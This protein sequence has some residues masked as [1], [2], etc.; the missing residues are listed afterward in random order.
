MASRSRWIGIPLRTQHQPSGHPQFLSRQ[1]APDWLKVVPE[2]KPRWLVTCSCGWERECVSECAAGS[3]S[4][5]HRQLGAVG[6]EHATHV[7]CY[8][9]PR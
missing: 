6:V 5:L 7:S 4:K 1:R 8:R 3:A 9:R 2:A